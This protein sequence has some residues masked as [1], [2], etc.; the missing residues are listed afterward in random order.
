M[1]IPVLRMMA[2]SGATSSSCIRTAADRPCGR[3]VGCTGRDL[4]QT[5]SGIASRIRRSTVAMPTISGRKAA[6]A[7]HVIE[8]RRD[9]SC[10]RLQGAG[11]RLVWTRRLAV[12]HSTVRL[13][14]EHHARG[15]N[16]GY[17]VGVVNDGDLAEPGTGASLAEVADREES[18]Q[19]LDQMVFGRPELKDR[20]AIVL[21]GG[22][23]RLGTAS[24]YSAVCCGRDRP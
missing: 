5:C 16:K 20:Q 14:R 6:R 2:S 17:P 12:D 19:I 9:H 21:L 15:G 1:P 10:V 22:L 23:G 24:Q 8:R 13:S 11:G 18:S 3:P 4:T 7:D